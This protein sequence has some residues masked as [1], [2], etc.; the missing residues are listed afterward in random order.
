[1]SATDLSPGLA[2]VRAAVERLGIDLPALVAEVSLWA[3][4]AAHA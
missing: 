4:P 2:A 1:M 3:P